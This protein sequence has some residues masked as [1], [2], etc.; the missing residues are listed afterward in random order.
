LL[1]AELLRLSGPAAIPARN[2]QF[3]AADG[4]PAEAA[5]GVTD[6]DAGSSRLPDAGA[7]MAL[8]VHGWEPAFVEMRPAQFLIGQF[9]RNP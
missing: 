9:A 6:A 3:Y 2:A 5:G 1:P 8:L 4:A 7:P